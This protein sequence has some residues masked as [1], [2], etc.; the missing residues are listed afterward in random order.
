MATGN[1]TSRTDVEL[2]EAWDDGDSASG[3][4]LLERYFDRL[5]VFFG[6]RSDPDVEDLVQRTMLAV[7]YTHLTLP[8]SDL[9]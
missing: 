7:S 2:L 1:E 3:N 8:T 9:V 4:A 5:L 6:P